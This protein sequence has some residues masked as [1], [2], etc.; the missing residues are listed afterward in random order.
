MAVWGLAEG[1]RRGGEALAQG[2]EVGGRLLVPGQPA[3]GSSERAQC[4]VCGEGRGSRPTPSLV[5]SS[6]NAGQRP[7][8]PGT[9]A[10]PSVPPGAQVN[11]VQMGNQACV[12]LA[13]P[14]GQ[15]LSYQDPCLIP[16]MTNPLPSPHSHPCLCS[17][18]LLKPLESP[19][20]STPTRANPSPRRRLAPQRPHQGLSSPGLASPQ[21]LSPAPWTHP[22]SGSAPLQELPPP[23]RLGLSSAVTTPELL[24]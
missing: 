22:P 15:P 2:Q 19:G 10:C 24:P 8:T 23:H 17:S 11:T 5:T 20:S 13:P 12:L 7:L 3:L 14:W 4:S 21:S 6:R 18:L 1:A 9:P 16:D